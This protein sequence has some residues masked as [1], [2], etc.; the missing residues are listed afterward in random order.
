MDEC[1]ILGY[2][3]TGAILGAVGQCARVAVGLKKAAESSRAGRRG[4]HWF[5]WSRLF[6]SILIGVVAGV[7]GAVGMWGAAIDREFMFGVVTAG[8]SGADFVEGFIRKSGG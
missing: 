6:I 8:Y 2:L 7:L 1:R 4:K 5:D 3:G